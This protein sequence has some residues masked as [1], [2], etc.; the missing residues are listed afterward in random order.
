MFYS[1]LQRLKFIEVHIGC[2]NILQYF[3]S[4]NYKNYLIMQKII[5]FSGLGTIA[6]PAAEAA[7]T[8]FNFDFHPDET[9]GME[10]TN[11]MCASGRAQLLRDGTFFFTAKPKRVRNDKMLIA[12]APHGRLSFTRDAARKLTLRIPLTESVNWERCFIEEPIQLLTPLI[13]R[14]NMRIL[15]TELLNEL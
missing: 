11:P 3:A 5:S 12:R 10:V 14:E 8:S 13:G 2:P 15:L 6:P 1:L 9:Q 4:S 7:Q